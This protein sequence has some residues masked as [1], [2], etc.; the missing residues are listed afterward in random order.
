M[1]HGVTDFGCGCQSHDALRVPCLCV[2]RVCGGCVFVCQAFARG[3]TAGGLT[4]ILHPV[5]QSFGLL[6]EAQRLRPDTFAIP[7]VFLMTVR[8]C[9]CCGSP[10]SLPAVTTHSSPVGV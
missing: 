6:A 5:Q 9:L 2:N 7:V 1:S 3:I 4:D 10:S 8:W